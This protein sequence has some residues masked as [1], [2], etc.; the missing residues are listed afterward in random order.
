MVAYRLSQGIGVF[1]L[2]LLCKLSPHIT[3]QQMTDFLIGKLSDQ[4]QLSIENHLEQCPECES[5]AVATQPEDPLI[6]SLLAGSESCLS[7]GNVE[8]LSS[9]TSPQTSASTLLGATLC[10]PRVIQPPNQS[11]WEGDKSSFEGNPCEWLQPPEELTNHARY[12]IIRPL[13]RGGMG[14]VW[15]AK[16]LIMGRLM[17]L[18]VI[19]SEH[20]FKADSLERFRREVQAAAKLHHN[21]VVTAFDA[22]QI[23]GTLF[24]VVEFIDGESLSERLLNGPLPVLEA[25]SAIRDAALGVAHAHASGMVHRDIKPG[26]L[27]QTPDGLVKVLDFGL[28]VIPRESSSITGENMIVGT[29]DYVAP[30]QAEDPH[31]ATS[32]SDVYSLGCTLYHLLS[33]SPPF[34][35]QSTL[36]KLDSH[37]NSEPP[38][39]ANVPDGLQT[40]VSKMMAKYPSDRFQSAMK[41]A[42]ALEDFCAAAPIA[43]QQR[44]ESSTIRKVNRRLALAAGLVAISVAATFDKWRRDTL[45]RTTLPVPSPSTSPQGAGEPIGIAHALLIPTTLGDGTEA[46]FQVDGDVLH[47][48]AMT[49]TYQVWMN[50]KYFESRQF[51]IETAIR[52][53]KL[54][55]ESWLK[56]ALLSD[57]GAEY[58]VKFCKN[59]NRDWLHVEK[60]TTTYERTIAEKN[61]STGVV[62]DW[63]NIAVYLENEHLS[64]FVR[65]QLVLECHCDEVVDRYPA[66]SV[67][68]CKVDL[69]A[70]RALEFN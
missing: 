66:V 13:G 4:E 8:S 34:A 50:F 25:C 37:R 55:K 46:D 33:G 14:T 18:K 5:L 9:A 3:P 30:E 64:I 10:Q 19:R 60:C 40:I 6:S 70:H 12:K 43:Q 32:L 27:I 39:I 69:R 17:A 35:G 48:D 24:L 44:L 36:R 53:V 7:L 1:E 2:A 22:E 54:A 29:P 62:G 16:H 65:D 49:N 45:P 61:M 11:S 28:V 26:N 38:A 63:T 68:G 21:N 51:R 52:F 31:Q 47:V 58:N 57:H 15:L 59:V 56:F 23:G 41:V 42:L 20:L 67:H